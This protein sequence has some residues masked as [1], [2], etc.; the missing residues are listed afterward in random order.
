MIDPTQ[1]REVI[2]HVLTELG[3]KYNSPEARD[4]VYNTGLVES[5]HF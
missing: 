2:D 1:M 4:L 5:R 3:D